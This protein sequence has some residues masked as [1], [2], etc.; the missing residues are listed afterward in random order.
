M[1]RPAIRAPL[2]SSIP[3]LFVSGTFDGRT[4]PANA[5]SLAKG[6]TRAELRVI[7]GASHSLFREPDALAAV[8]RFFDKQ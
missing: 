5:E 4:P 6:F 2:S 3:T 1:R 8:L 7:P